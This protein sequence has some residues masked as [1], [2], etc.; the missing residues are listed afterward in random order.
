MEIEVVE[1]VQRIK[2][3][4]IELKRYNIPVHFIH[5]GYG[6]IG[7]GYTPLLLVYY[8]DTLDIIEANAKVLIK[9]AKE[10]SDFQLFQSIYNKN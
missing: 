10:G 3:I 9:E 1:R 2:R 4:V 8:S 6:P 7:K 5:K